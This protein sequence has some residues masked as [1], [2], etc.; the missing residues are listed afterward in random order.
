MNNPNLIDGKVVQI[1]RLSN[2]GFSPVA[3][4]QLRVLLQEVYDA[5]AAGAPV[6]PPPP[7]RAKSKN[8]KA[9]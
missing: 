2:R 3:E 1:H 4:E 9:A 7:R 8:S 5:G 6:A